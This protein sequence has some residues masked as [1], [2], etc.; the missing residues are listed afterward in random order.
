MNE[1]LI[2]VDAGTSVCK[3]VAFSLDGS[4]IADAAVRNVYEQRNDGGAEQD[5]AGTWERCVAT[6]VALGERVPDL[7]SRAVGL[8]VTG[9]GDGTWL[10]DA[11]GEPAGPA[12]LWLDARA[13]S[14]VDRFRASDADVARYDTTG[15]LPDRALQLDRREPCQRIDREA[16]DLPERR[17]RG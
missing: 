16:A 6:L 9:Q 3:A 10:V 4:Q 7:A 12:L 13:G 15:V 1:I 11:A 17:Q 2:G 8:A 14:L 5:M